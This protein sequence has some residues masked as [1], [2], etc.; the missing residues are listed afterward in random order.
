[1]PQH[2]FTENLMIW[3]S[4]HLRPMPWKG[5]K[6]PYLIWLSEIILQQTQVQQG[7]PYFL[8][9]KSAYPTVH[10]LANADED[11]VMKRWQGLGYYSRARN[12]HA[13]AKYVSREL[14]GQFPETYEGLLSL[15]GVGA[16]TAAAIASFAFGK[17]VAVVDGNVYRVLTRFFGISE[18]IDTTIGKKQVRQLADKLLDRSDPGAY[19]QAIMDFGA[20]QCRPKKPQCSA[21]PMTSECVAFKENTVAEFPVKVKKI[22]K[23]TRYFNYLVIEFEDG[24]YL[25]KRQDN[26]IWKDLYQF[27]LIETDTLFSR[28]EIEEKISLWELLSKHKPL[29]KSVSGP[30]YQ[31]LTHQKI[32]GMFYKIEIECGLK[33]DERD[34]IFVERNNLKNFAVPKL[35]DWFLTDKSLSLLL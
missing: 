18:P 33:M 21:C 6:D 3:T 15:K 22:K 9:F 29:I 13:T 28:Q 7:K 34:L 16:Y 32:V 35:I 25:Q 4:T 1:M 24:V 12:L 14:D 26:D 5:E 17:P 8:K 20:D 19:N 27:L 11:E 23:K 31:N 2:F 10:D 30:F